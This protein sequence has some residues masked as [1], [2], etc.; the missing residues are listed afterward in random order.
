MNIALEM[1]CIYNITKA[2]HVLWLV[3]SASTICPW[4][5]AADVCANVYRA[6]LLTDIVSK[7]MAELFY[8]LLDTDLTKTQEA[9][10]ALGY[11]LVRLL[12]FFRA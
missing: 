5:Y 12:R 10:V 1:K 7:V 6:N 8:R 4:V 3:N 11:R 2:K 9:R